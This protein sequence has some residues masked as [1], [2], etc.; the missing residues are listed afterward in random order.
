V[1]TVY[2]WRT[3]RLL[4]LCG[5]RTHMHITYN[6]AMFYITLKETKW[7]QDFRKNRAG[8]ICHWKNAPDH[9]TSTTIV[10]SVCRMLRYDLNWTP[11]T[12]SIRQHLKTSDIS[13]LLAIAHW[14]IDRPDITDTTWFSDEAQIYLN[15]KVNKRNC[16]FWYTEK[17]IFN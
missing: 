1:Y 4:Y 3:S 2:I 14:M 10:S 6:T 9:I 13:N 7:S 11:Y 15:T 16:R 8:E 17:H 5:N 12:S